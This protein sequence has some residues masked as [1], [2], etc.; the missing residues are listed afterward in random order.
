MPKL[1]Q[2]LLGR[3]APRTIFRGMHLGKFCLSAGFEVF[4]M[5]KILDDTTYFP[6]LVSFYWNLVFSW[7]LWDIITNSTRFCFFLCDVLYGACEVYRCSHLR[8][9]CVQRD[10]SSGVSSMVLSAHLT[11]Q[12]CS[13][14]HGHCCY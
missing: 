13:Q 14:P 3:T 1:P 6:F 4:S 5:E 10:I 8:L 7:R 9:Q 12:V 2:T 11:L